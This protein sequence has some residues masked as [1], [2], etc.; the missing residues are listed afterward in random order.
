MRVVY[1]KN[2]IFLQIKLMSNKL[3]RL[4]GLQTGQLM[5][6]HTMGLVS[7][8]FGVPTRLTCCLRQT[9]T[10]SPDSG[11][12]YLLRKMRIMNGH[13]WCCV[14]NLRPST[15]HACSWLS[16]RSCQE[17]KP[18]H[19]TKLKWCSSACA[20]GLSMPAAIGGGIP[21]QLKPAGMVCKRPNSNGQLCFLL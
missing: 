5:S 14:I 13:N 17:N 9:G 1:L 18:P 10:T 16:R 2:N 8:L 6:S 20:G 3:F 7:L 21:A 12:R 4:W 15:H 11:V 19:Y